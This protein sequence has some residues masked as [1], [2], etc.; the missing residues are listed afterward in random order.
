M[1]GWSDPFPDTQ[2][3]VRFMS[4][5][6][7]TDRY[8]SHFLTLSRLSTVADTA[9]ISVGIVSQFNDFIY[10]CVTENSNIFLHLTLFQ[11]TVYTIHSNI[12]KGKSPFAIPCNVILVVINDC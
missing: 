5:S 4:H 12:F 6:L 11:Y 1:V 3:L 8:P 7:S 9:L 10:S 2:L